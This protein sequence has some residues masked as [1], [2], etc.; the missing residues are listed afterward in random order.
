MANG[1]FMMGGACFGDIGDAL[2]VVKQA[3]EASGIEEGK[4]HR[5]YKKRNPLM[6]K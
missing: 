5:L 4:K 1:A 6:V 2:G 3:F